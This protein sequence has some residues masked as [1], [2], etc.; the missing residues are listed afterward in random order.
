[1]IY[2]P[3]LMKITRGLSGRSSV[4]HTPISIPMDDGTDG[5]M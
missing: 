4:V 5:V 3:L 1:M 2:W